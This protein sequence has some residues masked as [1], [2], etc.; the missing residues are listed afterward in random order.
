MKWKQDST[1]IHQL[2]G[3]ARQYVNINRSS[4]IFGTL[5]FVQICTSY[6]IWKE[7]NTLY[8]ENI[9]CDN[10][11]AVNFIFMRTTFTCPILK[12]S[13]CV[14]MLLLKSV[15]MRLIHIWY[16]DPRNS[17]Y[18]AIKRHFNKPCKRVLSRPDIKRLT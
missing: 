18:S 4:P 9:P 10:F 1:I 7:D 11:L 14:W 12:T 17:L 13:Y 16:N 6:L 8:W 3:L 5:I 2:I 15:F